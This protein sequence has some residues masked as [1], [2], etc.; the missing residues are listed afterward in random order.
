MGQRLDDKDQ[1]GAPAQPLNMLL[2][3]RLSALNA[4][5]N[6]QAC[7][8][9]R[10]HGKLKLPEWRILEVLAVYGELTGTRIGELSGIDAGL[11]SRSLQ[12]LEQRGLVVLRRSSSDRRVIHVTNSESGSGL[13]DLIFPLME[14]RQKKLLNALHPDEQKLIFTIISKLDMVAIPQVETLPEVSQAEKDRLA[15]ANRETIG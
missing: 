5:L 1:V 10:H 3:Y 4:R 15:D 7:T 11:V 12:G 14:E 2:T 9:L 8:L 13:V 6:R